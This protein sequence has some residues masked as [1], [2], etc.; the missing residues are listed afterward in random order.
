M[1]PNGE[2]P[3][4]PFLGPGDDMSHEVKPGDNL[5]LATKKPPRATQPPYPPPDIHTNLWPQHHSGTT[6]NSHFDQVSNIYYEEI[7]EKALLKF[8]KQ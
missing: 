6:T 2:M 8:K 5:H 1:Q 3:G 7:N 4:R